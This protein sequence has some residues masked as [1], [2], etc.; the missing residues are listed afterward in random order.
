MCGKD[1]AK[2]VNWD[3]PYF[4]MCP[5]R[6]AS[7]SIICCANEPPFA[8][9]ES[10]M[11]SRLRRAS[12]R[13]DCQSVWIGGHG[14]SNAVNVLDLKVSAGVH[15]RDHEA[16]SFMDRILQPERAANRVFPLVGE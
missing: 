8:P 16:K 11:R 13:L 5:S 4:G 10:H 1:K 9:A 7:S 12:E 6:K 2:G 3:Q 15:G 14:D